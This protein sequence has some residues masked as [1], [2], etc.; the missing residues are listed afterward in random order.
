MQARKIARK[1]FFGSWFASLSFGID[2]VFEEGGEDTR[3][4]EDDSSWTIATPRVRRKREN[5]FL[6]ETRVWKKTMEKRAVVRSLS[7]Y[8]V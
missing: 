5:H 1:P 2:D 8:V 7:W 3:E 4:K 6:R